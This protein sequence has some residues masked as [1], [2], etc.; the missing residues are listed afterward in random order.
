M[1]TLAGEL[2]PTERKVLRLAGVLMERLA[3]AGGSRGLATRAA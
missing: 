3:E 1:T 2:M